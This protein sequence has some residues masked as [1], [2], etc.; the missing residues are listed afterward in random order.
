MKPLHIVSNAINDIACNNIEIIVPVQT[1]DEI[2]TLCESFNSMSRD[3][4]S[5]T[6]EL[7]K[8]NDRLAEAQQIAHVG[9]WE[10]NFV[11]NE[12][13][14]SDELHRIF[15]FAPQEFVV[16]YDAFLNCVH[17][18]DREFVKKSVDDALHGKNP[19][20]I[21][22]R[23]FHKDGSVRIIHEKGVVAFD[24]AGRGTRMVGM[25]QD[26]TEQKRASEEIYLLQTISIA[27]S[28]SGNLHDALVMVIQKICNFTGWVYG[29]A[30]K[31]NPDGT[32]LERDH[33]YYS[34]IEGFEKFNAFTEGMTFPLSI[35]LPGRAWSERQPVWIQDVTV[36]PYYLRAQI[37]REVG[38]KTGIAFPITT[39][40][41]VVSVI[42]FY[43]LK[44]KEKDERIMQVVLTVLS[45]IGS[46]VKRKQ[47]EEALRE[48]EEKLRSIL[49]NTTAVV[50]VK[51]V[52]GRY[53]FINRQFEKLF[54]LTRDAVKGKTDLDLWPK[55]M[56]EAFQ[57]NDRRVIES[58][59][60]I[61]FEEAAP[62]DD[63]LHTYISVK[64]PLFD[65]N[66]TVYAVCGVST[67]I[68]EHKRADDLLIERSRLAALGAEVGF[69][70]AQKDTLHDMLQKCADA[71][72]RNLNVAF[73]RIWTINKE[74]NVLELQSS[75]GIYTHIDGPHSRV[76]VGKYKIGL[77]AEERKPYLTNAV[78]S[79]PRVHDQ[80][81][82]KKTGMVAFAG[83]PLMIEDHIV[84][85]MAMFSTKP[86]TETALKHW[87]RYQI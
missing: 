37:A 25:S 77:L 58:K 80:E 63:G 57:A 40:N 42:V 23:I 70:L 59:T 64:F 55:E 78:I 67:D 8:S 7:E 79:D 73:A 24:H 60:P 45:Q 14:W 54:R 6:T 48:S 30:W 76:P 84:G 56:A 72:V 27:V 41:E 86:I 43:D 82:A 75:A 21:E 22:F 9:N 34:R 85:V 83:Y 10:W 61:E 17:P 69:S 39:D 81:W 31:P 66:G 16:T 29:E 28:A 12:A 38:L 53:L 68:T 15:G 52:Q 44:T 47:A 35:G 11:K 74:E 87:H 49:D 36:D 1:G 26:I 71:F 51:D 62:H 19:Y 18:D 4:K 32:L 46:I 13:Y 2:G 50:Y 33:A 5:R 65:V 3:I 20:N